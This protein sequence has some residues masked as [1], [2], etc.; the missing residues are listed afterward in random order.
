M[1]LKSNRKRL[2]KAPIPRDV[3]LLKNFL[4]DLID[5][6]Y[7]DFRTI[8]RPLMA[9]RSQE[10]NLSHV[11]HL[12]RLKLVDII[13][14]SIIK[15]DKKSPLG[16]RT[17]RVDKLCDMVEEKLCN[18]IKK[19]NFLKPEPVSHEELCA[20]RIPSIFRK[21]LYDKFI[22]VGQKQSLIDCVYENNASDE[23][24]AEILKEPDCTKPISIEFHFW[25]FESNIKGSEF[26]DY[27]DFENSETSF[28]Y[29][30]F[31]V[32]EWDNSDED[33]GYR[34]ISFEGFSIY[35]L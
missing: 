13:F 16:D 27:D 26:M 33:F 34:R 31:K 17:I 25:D 35:L 6:P 2:T 11:H 22:S 5:G 9:S 4:F 19:V 14:E 3:K 10:E 1:A 12:S 7:K 18:T 32:Y 15:I 29:I 24:C 20:E 30:S 28:Y 21:D 8:M 23:E